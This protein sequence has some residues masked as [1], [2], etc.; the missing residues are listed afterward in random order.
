MDRHGL[1]DAFTAAEVRKS[2]L[3][4][5][6]QMLEAQQRM[7]EAA[8]RFAEVAG[9]EERLAEECATRGLTAKAAL[10]RFSAAGCWARAGNFYQAILLCDD[11]LHRPDVGEPLRQRIQEYA[12]ASRSRRAQWL[13]GLGLL[14]APAGV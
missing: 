7:D 9:Q 2:N 14:A 6:G 4:L 11:L 8:R 12:H 10:H 5:E 3:I 13:T 1:D